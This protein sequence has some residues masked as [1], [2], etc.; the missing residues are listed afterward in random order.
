MYALLLM[1]LWGGGRSPGEHIRRSHSLDTSIVGWYGKLC[2][3]LIVNV[4]GVARGARFCI[5]DKADVGVDTLSLETSVQLNG[6][7]WHFWLKLRG[8][9][10]CGL[11]LAS[12]LACFAC[13]VVAL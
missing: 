3:Q 10:L 12:T 2:P 8:R 4:V 13:G 11:M 7:V 6:G 1:S 9:G 5:V